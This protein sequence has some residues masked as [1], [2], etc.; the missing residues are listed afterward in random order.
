[1]LMP[2][3]YSYTQATTQ[4]NKKKREMKG[5]GGKKTNE[6]H[7]ERTLWPNDHQNT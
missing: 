3:D 5:E 2:L 6:G 7:F 1:M 4:A